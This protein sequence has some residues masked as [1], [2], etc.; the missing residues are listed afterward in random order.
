MGVALGL[1]PTLPKKEGGAWKRLKNS[2]DTPEE[3]WNFE[4]PLLQIL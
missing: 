4:G 3:E 2:P 1:T